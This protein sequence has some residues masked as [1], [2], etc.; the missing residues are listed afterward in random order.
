MTTL[1]QAASSRPTLR[2]IPI[3]VLFMAAA[4]WL[5]R[6][7]AP[8]ALPSLTVAEPI[9]GRVTTTQAPGVFTISRPNDDDGG[10]TA[11]VYSIVGAENGYTTLRHESGRELVMPTEAL[12]S[13]GDFW[14]ALA[15][16]NAANGEKMINRHGCENA[17]RTPIG[18]EIQRRARMVHISGCK[19]KTW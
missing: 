16:I 4:W 1:Y 3:I 17:T 14:S 18:G 7:N 15:E 8:Q 5:L 6:A 11:I 19:G 12:S 2:M 10:E 9:V 13:S